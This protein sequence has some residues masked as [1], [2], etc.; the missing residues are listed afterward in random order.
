MPAH[1]HTVHEKEKCGCVAR[2]IGMLNI[3]RLL[4]QQ[5]QRQY[6]Y[7]LRYC[8]AAVTGEEEI[9]CLQ[10]VRKAYRVVHPCRA[11]TAYRRKVVT[12]FEY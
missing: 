7:D 6:W 9:P 11:A 10:Q 4:S 1:Y 3:S 5:Q 12:Q 2:R 8:T